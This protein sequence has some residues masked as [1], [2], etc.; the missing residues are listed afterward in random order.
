M[1]VNEFIEMVN[2]GL[3]LAQHEQDTGPLPILLMNGDGSGCKFSQQNGFKDRLNYPRISW[4]IPKLGRCD[5]IGVPTYA[6]SWQEF[7]GVPSS[8]SWNERVKWMTTKYPWSKKINKAVWRGSTTGP[9]GRPLKELARGKLVEKS[10]KHPQLIDAGFTKLNQRYTGMENETI[11]TK[12]MPFYDQ[13]NFKAIID[14]DG[15]SWS[16]RF[17]K[18]L[19]TNSVVIKVCTCISCIVLFDVIVL[20]FFLPTRLI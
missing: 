17:P 16:S 12:R 7:K 13:M 4:S 11:L 8:T 6:P 9:N 3:N 14:I 19:C 2:F 10:M 20:L 15:N 1:R 5:A 18:L